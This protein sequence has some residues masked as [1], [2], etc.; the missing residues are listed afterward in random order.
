MADVPTSQ[1]ADSTATTHPAMVHWDSHAK[2]SRFLLLLAVLSIVGSA[3][4]QFLTVRAINNSRYVVVLDG[5]DTFYVSPLEADDLQNPVFARTAILGAEVI[6]NRTPSG[7]K[8]PELAKGLLGDV[9][10]EKL[11]E[12]VSSGAEDMKAKSMLWEPI[13]RSTTA[14][15]EVEGL[16]IY[17]VRGELVRVGSVGGGPFIDPIQFNLV[18]AMEP[19]PNLGKRGQFPFVVSNYRFNLTRND[20]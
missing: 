16:R 13:V 12:E 20:E 18:L 10:W 5:S 6:L 4:V 19:N 15:R 14:M 8:L 7:L 1:P 9:A 2:R 11:R 3:A 17:Q